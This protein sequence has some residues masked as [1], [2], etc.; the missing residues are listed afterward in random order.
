MHH[1][2]REIGSICGINLCAALAPDTACIASHPLLFDHAGH[3]LQKV[4]PKP[5]DRYH[6]LFLVQRLNFSSCC[7]L[8]LSFSNKING[9]THYFHSAPSLLSPALGLRKAHASALGKSC[10]FNVGPLDIDIH[11][12]TPE[13]ESRRAACMKKL[14]MWNVDSDSLFRSPRNELQVPR[15]KA[16]SSV[17]LFVAFQSAASDNWDQVGGFQWFSMSLAAANPKA[18]SLLPKCPYYRSSQVLAGSPAMTMLHDQAWNRLSRK[19]SKNRQNSRSSRIGRLSWL[20]RERSKHHL[21]WWVTLTLT[22]TEK[23]KIS[24][25][26]CVCESVIVSTFRSPR[27]RVKDICKSTSKA[28]KVLVC[29]DQQKDLLGLSCPT[30]MHK[31]WQI[32]FE[33]LRSFPRQEILVSHCRD[34]RIQCFFI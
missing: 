5:P 14:I 3:L 19:T 4:Q 17:H 1:F 29:L 18:W 16:W 6:L 13:F 22:H 8:L 9:L 15:Y 11:P 31:F 7:S 30:R 10:S 27:K 2:S 28:R 25:F 21:N 32:F 33:M 23:L 24:P 26:K 12:N 34:P 20:K